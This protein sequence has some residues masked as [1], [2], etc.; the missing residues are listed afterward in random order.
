MAFFL[1]ID[2]AAFGQLLYPG[3]FLLTFFAN[4]SV[5]VP[6]PYVPIV[7]RVADA[8]PSAALVVAAAAAGSMLGESVS[9]FVGRAGKQIVSGSRIY[10]ALERLVHRPVLAGIL[11]FLLAAPLN[12][13]FDI[14]GLAAGAL[15][16]RYGIFAAA[17]FLGRLTR[18]AVIVWLG[19]GLMRL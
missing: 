16:L 3:V 6:V 8:A 11:L 14:A 12:P 2:Y 9:Y 1:P 13:F 10:R 17:V 19:A 7:L 15:G 4:A 18:F 5:V